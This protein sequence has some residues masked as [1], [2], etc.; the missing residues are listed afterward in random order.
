MYIFT[1]W[2]LVL[3]FDFKSIAQN[4]FSMKT[5]AKRFYIFRNPEVQQEIASLNPITDHQRMV[6][7]MTAYEFPFDMVRSLELALFHTYASPSISILLQKTGEFVKRGQ[8]RY[9]DTGILIAQFM[10]AGYDSELGIRAI[11]QMN[12]IHGN[13]RIAN[14]DYLLVLSTFVFYPINWM[15]VNGWRKMT[16]DEKLALFLFFKEVAQRMNLT[17]IPEDF[18]ALKNFAEEYEQKHFR[19]AESNKVIADATI[20][21]VENWFPSFLRFAVKPVFAASI[22]EKLRESFGYK[23]PSKLF[24]EMLNMSFQIRKY[25]L[26]YITFKKYPTE[27]SNTYYRT[28]PK[29]EFTIETLGPEYLTKKK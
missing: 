16:E 21:I 10:Q 11:N 23:K 3:L 25:F 22:T 12:K 5:Y 1:S 28:Y 14:E 8:K 24:C 20:K 4:H 7:L 6:Y 9:D 15:K 19:Y 18:E 2:K 29:H 26:K 13:Y 27:I 17:D